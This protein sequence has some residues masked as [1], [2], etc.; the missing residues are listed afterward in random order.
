MGRMTKDNAIA[1]VRRT[2]DFLVGNSASRTYLLAVLAAA[3]FLGW[4]TLAN[5]SGPSFAGIYLI[6]LTSPGSWI[7]VTAALA[8][9]Q[10]LTTAGVLA[11]TVFGALVNTALISSIVRST[12]G[13][14][15]ARR[16]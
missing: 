16:A 7:G 12:S 11:G 9:P 6:G 2:T 3:V 15:R 8:G 1:R 4:D 13:A 10:W 5:D 14:R